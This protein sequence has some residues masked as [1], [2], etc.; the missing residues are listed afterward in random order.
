MNPKK[1]YFH[2]RKPVHL[3]KVIGACPGAKYWLKMI[4][5]K[6]SG[7]GGSHSFKIKTSLTL[8]LRIFCVYTRTEAIYH[9]T[10]RA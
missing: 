10:M 2:S 9:I 6:G 3:F 8:F 7:P 1:R 4:C 5:I